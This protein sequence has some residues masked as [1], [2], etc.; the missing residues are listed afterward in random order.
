MAVL[1]SSCFFN[2]HMKKQPKYIILDKKISY[3]TNEFIWYKGC[4]KFKPIK[5]HIVYICDSD[6]TI[7][8]SKPSDL[9]LD[10]TK[11]NYEK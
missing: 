9:N 4:I 6:Y 10:T 2:V 3:Q 1:L 8:G 11:F 5:Q 7:N